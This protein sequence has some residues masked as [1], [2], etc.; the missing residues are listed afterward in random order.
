M[1]ELPICEVKVMCKVN[2]T[3]LKLVNSDLCSGF[4]VKSGEWSK[5][6]LCVTDAPVEVLLPSG[7]V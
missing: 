5:D 1:V 7:P 3:S 4:E 2:A 6:E